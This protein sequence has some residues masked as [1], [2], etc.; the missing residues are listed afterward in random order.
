[1]NFFWSQMDESGGFFCERGLPLAAL[2]AEDG[3]LHRR[4]G[5]H[6]P[7]CSPSWS[8]SSHP[9]WRTPRC[10]RCLSGTWRGPRRKA[11][12]QERERVKSMC[13]SHNDNREY[14][15]FRLLIITFAT[16]VVTFYSQHQSSSLRCARLEGNRSSSSL[17]E[18]LQSM[19]S[20]FQR[21][22]RACHKP[23]CPWGPSKHSLGAPL[24]LHFWWG[25][26]VRRSPRHPPPTPPKKLKATP[27]WPSWL[28]LLC[29][30]CIAAVC[31]SL[32]PALCPVQRQA[33]TVNKDLFFIT[34]LIK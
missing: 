9:R 3:Q 16:D 18:S 34:C 31:V 28:S 19:H 32:S 26:A 22:L 5:S 15:P 4:H 21:G 24:R 6:S 23:A 33:V 27:F 30:S 13:T 17:Q 25:L 8:L 7:V 10:C 2:Q 11:A 12:E 29:C 1:M 20:L 14:I